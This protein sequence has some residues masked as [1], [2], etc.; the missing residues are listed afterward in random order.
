MGDNPVEVR[1]LFGALE[2]KTLPMQGFRASGLMTT[3]A[4]VLA[5]ARGPRGAARGSDRA[6]PRVPRPRLGGVGRAVRT[7]PPK[8]ARPRLD[9]SIGRTRRGPRHARCLVSYQPRLSDA[10]V[11]SHCAPFA[12]YACRIRLVVSCHVR[13]LAD[14]AVRHAERA[15]RSADHIPCIS[16]SSC[17]SGDAGH[18]RLPDP[19]RRLKA[20]GLWSASSPGHGRTGAATRQEHSGLKH[21]EP[22]HRG[23]VS[24]LGVPPCPSSP[25]APLPRNRM[26]LHARTPWPSSRSGCEASTTTA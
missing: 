9:P 6:P 23:T 16:A 21:P 18:P 10:S 4:P 5:S 25:P 2:T 7:D 24:R 17:C 26:R 3:R 19:P 1:V 8:N 15:P 14:S 12:T 11:A 22:T 20:R 13:H